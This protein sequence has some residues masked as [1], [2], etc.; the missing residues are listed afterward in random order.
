MTKFREKRIRSSLCLGLLLIVFSFSACEGAAGKARTPHTS[1]FF[2]MDTVMSVTV[3]GDETAADEAEI[4]VSD[5]E[6]KL[7]VTD[8]NSDVA[9]LNRDKSAVVS[10]DT[11]NVIK[12]SLELSE[13]TDGAIDITVYPVVKAWGFTT[14]EYR[15]PSLE[16]L[17]EL[18]ETVDHRKVDVSGENTETGENTVTIADDQT[19]DLGCIAKGYTGDAVIKMLK[20]KGVQSAI[21]NLGG[22]VQT[23]GMKPGGGL[24]NVGITDPFDL[25]GYAG[26]LY[27]REKC[28]ITSGGYERYFTSENVRYH[29]IID[30]KT[31]YPA[32]SGLASVTVVGD[33]GVICDALSTAL[34][35]LGLEKATEFYRNSEDFE[36]VFITESGELF[37]TEGLRDAFTP[38]GNYEN[39]KITVIEHENN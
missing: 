34:F 20:E 3:Y 36:A 8:E 16:E 21:V 17:G 15:V 31:G 23:L 18:L 39:K 28:V 33:S 29:H 10:D 26:S 6:K 14:G 37:I 7:S 30:T 2:A 27:V 35:A 13:R 25:S 12:T 19:V 32:T 4:L 38:L 9:R 11:Y 22:N 5:L 1:T 24:W